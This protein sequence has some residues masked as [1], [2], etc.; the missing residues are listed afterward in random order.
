MKLKLYTIHFF[1]LDERLQANQWKKKGLAMTPV[2]Y[3]MQWKTCDF[4]A[5][6]AIY[7]DG[8]VAVSVGGVEMGQGLYTKV[9]TWK[10]LTCM[11]LTYF[12]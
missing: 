8:T 11:P 3:A 6:T 10:K 9:Y 1:I 12:I 4:T 5:F 7:K 2:K